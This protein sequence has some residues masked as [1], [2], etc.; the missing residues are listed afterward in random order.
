MNEISNESLGTLI[1]G[2]ADPATCADVQ[3]I[4][5]EIV[6]HPEMAEEFDWNIWCDA[7]DMFCLGI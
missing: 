7:F 4:A 1:G 6:N 5:N 3:Y 2:W